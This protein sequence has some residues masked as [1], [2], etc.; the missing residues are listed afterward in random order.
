MTQPFNPKSTDWSSYDV[1]SLWEMVASEQEWA[2]RD[3]VSAWRRMSEVLAAHQENLNG[4]QFEVMK[5]WPPEGS[6]AAREFQGRLDGLIS[7]A[8]EGASAAGSNASALNLLTD[9]LIDAKSQIE[10]LYRSWQSATPQQKLALNQQA[11]SIMARTDVLVLEHGGQFK[12]PPQVPVPD[13]DTWKADSTLGNQ[14]SRP[15][16]STAIPAL[17]GPASRTSTG[18]GPVQIDPANGPDI[19][20]PS[21]K[22][23]VLSGSRPPTQ[24]A[25]PTRPGSVDEVGLAPATPAEGGLQPV[26]GVLGIPSGAV[27]NSGSERF[28]PSASAT[29][30]EAGPNPAFDKKAVG[31][32]R[33][34]AADA[35]VERP[36]FSNGEPLSGG[37][38]GGGLSP[39]G[40]NSLGTRQRPYPD[41]EE[42]ELPTGVR[43]VIVPDPAPLPTSFDPGPDVLGG[44]R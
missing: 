44:N 25:G 24:P 17:E 18:A 40:R 12:P 34:A 1:P 31:P 19:G 20:L 2:N 4:I 16:G 38:I 9:A 30:T 13:T 37:V 36:P 6:A 5:Q 10:P 33:A 41:Q 11:R 7:S 21:V 22:G 32:I 8:Q 43:P 14:S 23:P 42:W 35:R 39:S 27:R 29:N 3:Q 26:P 28:D 15:A